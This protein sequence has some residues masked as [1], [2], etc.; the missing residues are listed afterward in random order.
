MFT[1]FH[2]TELQ[3]RSFLEQQ[4]SLPY[5]YPEVGGTRS[6]EA[7]KGYNND[8]NFIELGKGDAIWETAKEAI[9]Q[10]RMFPGGWAYIAPGTPPIAAG[11]VV[12]MAARVTGMWWLNSC[13]IVYVLDDERQFGFA[14]GTLPGHAERGEEVFMVEKTPDGTV[15]YVIKAFSWPRHWL[16]RLGYGLARAYQ[17]KFVHDS[18]CSML[19]SVSHV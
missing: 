13:R 7:L 6:D 5:S 2:P 11:T 3:I 12:A 17:R 9:R 10:W 16:A 1:L 15:R 8:F 19:Q 14:Y 18:K 4:R